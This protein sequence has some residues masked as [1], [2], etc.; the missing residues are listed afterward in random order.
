MMRY[1][2]TAAGHHIVPKTELLAKM[3]TFLPAFTMR[4]I[5]CLFGHKSVT[6]RRLQAVFSGFSDTEARSSP[7]QPPEFVFPGRLLF[8]LIV[9]QGS[10]TS[11]YGLIRISSLLR[12]FCY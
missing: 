4:D 2:A 11:I 8:V 3:Q 12:V 6:K 1:G 7:V 10:V 5:H 9:R